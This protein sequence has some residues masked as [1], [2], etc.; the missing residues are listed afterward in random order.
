MAAGLGID[1]KNTTF[2]K[3]LK[4]HRFFNISPIAQETFI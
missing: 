3:A 2:Y 4:T 1:D